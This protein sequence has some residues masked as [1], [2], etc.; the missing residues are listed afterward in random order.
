MQL[1]IKTTGL[2]LGKTWTVPLPVENSFV[3]ALESGAVSAGVELD[4]SA[5]VTKDGHGGFHWALTLHAPGG[6]SEAFDITQPASGVVGMLEGIEVGQGK[7]WTAAV[8]VCA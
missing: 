5:T 3:T 1:L 4:A 7:T 8:T 6:L 2:G